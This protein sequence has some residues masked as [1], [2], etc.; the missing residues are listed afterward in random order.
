M[1]SNKWQTHRSRKKAKNTRQ[2]Q[3]WNHATGPKTSE[4]K[5]VASLNAIKHG[6]TCADILALSRALYYHSLILNKIIDTHV[7]DC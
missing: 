1:K 6:G 2:A 3:P 7:K 4:G 5:Q